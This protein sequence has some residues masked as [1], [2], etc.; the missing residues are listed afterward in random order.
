M[1][2]QGKTVEELA[3]L[4]QP[5]RRDAALE[6]A[7]ILLASGVNDTNDF[8]YNV[9]IEMTKRAEE[10]TWRD[11]RTAPRDRFVEVRWGKEEG[12]ACLKAGAWYDRNHHRVPHPTQWRHLP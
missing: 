11:R 5:G 12:S 2:Y 3:E 6:F 9:W 1:N 8:P 7:K 10:L 4:L